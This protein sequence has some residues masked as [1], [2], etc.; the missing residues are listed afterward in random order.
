MLHFPAFSPVVQQMI[1]LI[2]KNPA[3]MEYIM[4]YKHI[5]V[6]SQG[7]KITVNEDY[8]L[9]VPNNPIIPYIEGDGTGVDITP[10]M[11][12]VVNAA[13][14]KAYGGSNGFMAGRPSRFAATI[15]AQYSG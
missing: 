6:P 5:Q 8:S 9:N 12:D 13:V 11:I 7:E 1:P 2:S 15:R 10:V 4:G 3:A 14:E